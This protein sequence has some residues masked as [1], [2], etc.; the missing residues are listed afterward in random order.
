MLIMLPHCLPCPTGF[1]SQSEQD[2]GQQTEGDQSGFCL[3]GLN[4]IKWSNTNCFRILSNFVSNMAC[5]CSLAE[6]SPAGWSFPHHFAWCSLFVDLVA[7]ET[8]SWVSRPCLSETWW[9]FPER[10][11]WVKGWL[12]P[13]ATLEKSWGFQKP[14]DILKI[15]LGWSQLPKNPEK[16]I[17]FQMGKLRSDYQG[18]SGN[19]VA[20]VMKTEEPIKPLIFFKLGQCD[21]FAPDP[22]NHQGVSRNPVIFWSWISG[23]KCDW[24]SKF[25]WNIQTKTSFGYFWCIVIPSGKF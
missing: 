17:T 22:A 4:G 11:P 21:W 15:T 8:G 20:K 3:K 14:R 13:N 19:H 6:N 12:A 18:V 7:S 23:G 2:I 16:P 24:F 25:L 1:Q 5:C 10:V 9:S